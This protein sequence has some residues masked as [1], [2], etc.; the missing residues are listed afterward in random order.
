MNC[1]L[2]LKQMIK[3]ET[4][5]NNETVMMLTLFGGSRFPELMYYFA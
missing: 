1:D 5:Q 2:D 3:E 4:E